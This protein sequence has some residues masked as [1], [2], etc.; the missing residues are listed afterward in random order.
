MLSDSLDRRETQW[1]VTSEIYPCLDGV[2]ER[3]VT[4]TDQSFQMSGVKYVTNAIPSV[5]SDSVF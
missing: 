1:N 2:T 3:R 5:Q 4:G